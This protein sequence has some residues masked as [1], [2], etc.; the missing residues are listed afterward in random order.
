MSLLRFS[1]FSSTF[2]DIGIQMKQ[3]NDAKQ[4]HKAMSLFNRYVQKQPTSLIISQ[5]LKA[6][7][8]LKDFDRGKTIHQQLSPPL[9]SNPFVRTNLI[10]LYSKTMN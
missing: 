5:A 7:I 1:R 9:L 10:Q 2:V 8:H 6:C 4:F 3:M